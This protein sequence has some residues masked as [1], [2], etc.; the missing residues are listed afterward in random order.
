M[1]GDCRSSRPTQVELRLHC[2]GIEWRGRCVGSVA[3]SSLHAI[4]AS[5][6]SATRAIEPGPTH[7]ACVRA[8]GIP[9][10]HNAARAFCVGP[11]TL[12]GSAHFAWFCTFCV[13][14]H[15]LQPAPLVAQALISFFMQLSTHSIC[16]PS[17]SRPKSSKAN[18][19]FSCDQ[20]AL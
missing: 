9:R 3:H 14:S 19:I 20:A 5:T 11:R 18:T 8:L 4:A 16:Y 2:V 12:R 17:K 7:F 1:P 15:T 6:F 13:G 10:T